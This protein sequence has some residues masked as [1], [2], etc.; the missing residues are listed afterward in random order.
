MSS[1]FL[2]FKSKNSFLMVNL[3]LTFFIHFIMIINVFIWSFWSLCCTQKCFLDLYSFVYTVIFYLQEKVEIP[4]L[5]PDLE[6][7]S[8]SRYFSL[9]ISILQYLPNQSYYPE[10]CNDKKKTKK[11]TLTSTPFIGHKHPSVKAGI[12]PRTC[13]TWQTNTPTRL[14]ITCHSTIKL[15]FTLCKKIMHLIWFQFC[16]PLCWVFLLISV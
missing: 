12:T 14:C 13:H 1:V 16:S 10:L 2:F 6:K 9:T 15:T 3:K 11:T 5:F 4:W 7:L 8:F